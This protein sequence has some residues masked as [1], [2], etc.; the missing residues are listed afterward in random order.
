MM[1]S[2]LKELYCGN[3]GFDSRQYSPDSPFS[4]AAHKSWDYRERLTASLNEAELELFE[5]Y[6]E[7]QGTIESITW[8][9]IYLDSLQF[10]MLLMMEIFLG[11]DYGAKE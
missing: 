7:E 2:M 3:V 5:Q 9:D 11:S 10:G 8:Y 1:I 4:K 6:C